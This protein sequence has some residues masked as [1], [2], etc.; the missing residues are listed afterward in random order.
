MIQVFTEIGISEQTREKN[1]V[2]E[3]MVKCWKNTQ[4]EVIFDQNE[5]FSDIVLWI[6]TTNSRISF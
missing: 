6:L 2:L 1:N 4:E 5:S 3:F